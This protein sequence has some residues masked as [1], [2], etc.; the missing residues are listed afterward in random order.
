PRFIMQ[1]RSGRAAGRSD[2]ADHL[3]DPDG[4]ADLHV[5]L[6]EMAVAGGEPVAMVDLD[7]AAVT[8]APAR[9]DDLAV[10]GGADGIARLGAEVEPGMHRGSAEEGIR[11]HAEARGEFDFADDGLAVGHERKRAGQ[12]VHLRTRGVDAVELPI[13][14]TGIPGQFDRNERPA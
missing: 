11:A 1:V 7:H 13:E 4:V 5:D 6:R 12:A 3:S 2:L 10:R 9:G 8:A 14:W